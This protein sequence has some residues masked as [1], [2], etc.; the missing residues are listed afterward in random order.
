MPPTNIYPTELAQRDLATA[1][2]EH[3]E[4]QAALLALDAC[5][6]AARITEEEAR[7]ECEEDFTHT[8]LDSDLSILEE[9]KQQLKDLIRKRAWQDRRVVDAAI[10]VDDARERLA[11]AQLRDLVV[12]CKAVEAEI[13]QLQEQRGA[14]FRSISLV[15]EAQLR[16]R[17]EREIKADYLSGALVRMYS[18]SR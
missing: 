9:A 15:E 4:E 7:Q 8:G 17:E 18:R 11:N 16:L 5:I 6:T 13:R 3:T 2:R 10:Q 12:R 1:E 14:I